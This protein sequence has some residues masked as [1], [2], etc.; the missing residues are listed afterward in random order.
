MARSATSVAVSNPRPN[1]TPT[2]Y[3][4]HSGVIDLH[5]PAE[6]PGHQPAVLQLLLEFRL[7]EVAACASIRATRTM[8]ARTIRLK[9]AMRNRNVAE[10]TV[11]NTL[12]NC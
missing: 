7:V 10:T 12:P 2:G 9:T 4:C 1:T 6:Q 3:I 11:P 8:P 5:P